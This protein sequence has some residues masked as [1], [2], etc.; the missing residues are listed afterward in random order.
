MKWSPPGRR[1]RERPQAIWAGG[2]RGL[3][4]ETGLMEEDW[5]GKDKW[6]KKIS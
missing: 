4:G 1:N 3:M 2:I 5:N 6:K